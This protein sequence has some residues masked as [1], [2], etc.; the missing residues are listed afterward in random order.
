MYTITLEADFWVIRDNGKLIA[1]FHSKSD[2]EWF[3][4][5]LEVQGNCMGCCG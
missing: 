2:A 3:L 1:S 5:G 4:D